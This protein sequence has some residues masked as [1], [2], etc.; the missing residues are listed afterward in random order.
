[1]SW[2]IPTRVCSHEASL[3][4]IASAP[5]IFRRTENLLQGLAGVGVYIG[6]ILVAGDSGEEHVCCLEEVLARVKRVRLRLQK[7]KCH[8]GVS[9][10]EILG[11]RIDGGKVYPL[12]DKVDVV[13][14]A[15][16]PRN[17]KQLK[18]FVGLL[19]YY[20]YVYFRI[21]IIRISPITLALRICHIYSFIICN[22]FYHMYFL[23]RPSCKKQGHTDTTDRHTLVNV[24]STITSLLSLSQNHD[25]TIT[26]TSLS[27]HYRL[28]LHRYCLPLHQHGFIMQLLG[29]P[30]G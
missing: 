14:N 9:L 24:L 7:A 8:V 4:G 11:H 27:H 16:T 10:V 21:Q 6:N 12:T 30:L 3:Y 17:V 1:M 5:D 26:S 23:Q 19:I 29:P 15:P 2:S 20:M 25:G 18:A 13:V 22:V 28:P